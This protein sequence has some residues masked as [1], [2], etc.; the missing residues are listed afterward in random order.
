MSG[1]ALVSGQTFEFYSAL[2]VFAAGTGALLPWSWRWQLL[3]NF[4]AIAELLVVY[5][6]PRD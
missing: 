2:L 6:F 4:L 1:I 5:G 3:F